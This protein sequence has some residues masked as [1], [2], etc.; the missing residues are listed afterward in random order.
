MA[1]L[2]G[3][4][5]A[6][7]ALEPQIRRVGVRDGEEILRVEVAAFAQLLGHAQG[8]AR[9]DI[10]RPSGREREKLAVEA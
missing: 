4:H 10:G 8:Q 1:L 7:E 2:A 5:F 3:E 9:L 6:R